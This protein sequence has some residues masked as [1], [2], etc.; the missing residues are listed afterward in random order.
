MVHDTKLHPVYLTSKR[1]MDIIVALVLLIITLPLTL[2]VIIML[3]FIFKRNPFYV[4]KRGVTIEHFVCN[5]IKFRTMRETN[6]F[7]EY[8]DDIVMKKSP[9][10]VICP[11]CRWLRKTGIDELPQVFNVLNGEMSIIGP[12]PLSFNDLR[13]IKKS[14]ID[15][16]KRRSKLKSKPGITGYWQIYGNRREGLDNLIELDEIYEKRRSFRMDLFLMTMTLPVMIFAKHTDALI[17][18]Q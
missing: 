2:I 6:Q 17:S 13:V 5:V 9:T 16:Y 18:Q 12:R 3:L 15:I 7:V 11:F 10:V 14:K 1:I 8:A 4:Q